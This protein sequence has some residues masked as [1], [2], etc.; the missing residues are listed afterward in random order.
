M[1]VEPGWRRQLLNCMSLGITACPGPVLLGLISVSCL[2]WCELPAVLPHSPDPQWLKPWAV[3]RG[4]QSQEWERQPKIVLIKCRKL[5]L[6]SASRIKRCRSLGKDAQSLTLLG[7]ALQQAEFIGISSGLLRLISLRRR[8]WKW[9]GAVQAFLS[10]F[11][12]P[13]RMRCASP[14]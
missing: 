7:F 9:V 6:R 13:H 3:S 4:V 8:N 10:P 5:G 1:E 12:L 14:L 2:T 11:F